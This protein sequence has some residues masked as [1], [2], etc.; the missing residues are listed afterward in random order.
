MKTSTFELKAKE[1]KNLS[2]SRVETPQHTRETILQFLSTFSDTPDPSPDLVLQLGG[3]GTG[4]PWQGGIA[5]G[6]R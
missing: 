4:S 1:V 2:T 6:G 3:R 5:A